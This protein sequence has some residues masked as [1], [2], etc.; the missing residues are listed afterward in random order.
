MSH[1]ID[2][3][4]ADN[5]RRDFIGDRRLRPALTGTHGTIKLGEHEIRASVH[6]LKKVPSENLVR[7]SR[8]LDFG[9]VEMHAAHLGCGDEPLRITPEEQDSGD[10]GLRVVEQ[11]QMSQDIARWRPLG[12]R[13]LPLVTGA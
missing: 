3:C 12:K 1:R 8:S 5:I 2:D 6:L 7:R 9:T 10:R 4:L 11:V 13:E